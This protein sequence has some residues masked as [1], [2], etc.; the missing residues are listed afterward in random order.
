MIVYLLAL[1]L[2]DG[3]I[4][5]IILNTNVII[6]NAEFISF[7]TKFIDFNANRY[8]HVVLLLPVEATIMH[9]G[10][11]LLERRKLWCSETTTSYQ[12]SVNPFA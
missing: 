10:T 12:L 7:N 6:F 3:C 5:N 1:D 9:A 8:L 11:A 2:L 4:Q